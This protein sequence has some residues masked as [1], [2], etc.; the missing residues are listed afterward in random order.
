MRLFTNNGV[1][2]RDIEQTPEIFW[3]SHYDA[4]SPISNGIPGKIVVRFSEGLIPGKALEL[5]C[6]RGDDAVW[7][8]QQ[9]WQVTAV[10]LSYRAIEYAAANA[11]RSGVNINFERHDL[12]Q[13]FPSGEFDLVVASF[14]ESPL[15]FDRA[16]LFRAAFGHLAPGGLL[17]ITSHG[18]VPNWS[19]HVRPFL[20]ASEVLA[21]LGPLPQGWEV[22][23]CD[24]VSRVMTGPEG[25][26][27]EVSDAV[28]ALK[29][30]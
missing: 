20:P 5:G 8:A 28:V 26:Q 22:Q 16:P 11:S 30:A 14:L 15:E 13:T 25:Q 2:M 18:K 9:G 7:L 3:E 21:S 23:F 12:T 10:D 29:R 4:M 17:L 24:E 1:G 27:D 6:G 19:K